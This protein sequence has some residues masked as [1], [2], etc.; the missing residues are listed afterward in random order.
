MTDIKFARL[1]VVDLDGTLALNHHR[2]HFVEREVGKKDWNAFFDACDKDEL[3]FP[4]FLTMQAL[5][6]AG[7]EVEIWSGRTARVK[8]KTEDWLARHGIFGFP[9][10]MREEGDHRADTVLKAEWLAESNTRPFLCIDD[11]DSVVQMWRDAGIVCFQ[12]APGGF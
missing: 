11:R 6:M 3:N 2:T 4:V 8:A 7:C 10:R 1:V 9:L 5:R 12:V